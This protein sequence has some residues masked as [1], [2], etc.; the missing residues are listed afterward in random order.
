MKNR[1]KYIYKAKPPKWSMAIKLK[2]Y[3][4]IDLFD[5]ILFM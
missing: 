1:V 2:N 4:K 3:N 5:D